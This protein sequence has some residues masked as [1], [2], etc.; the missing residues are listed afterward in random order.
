MHFNAAETMIPVGHLPESEVTA[1]WAKVSSKHLFNAQK[2]IAWACVHECLPT[3][4]FQ[5]RRAVTSSPKCPRSSCRADETV[6]H[7]LWDCSYAKDLWGKAKPLLV[8]VAGIKE[9]TFDLILYGKVDN[10]PQAKFVVLWKILNSL[11]EAL[12]RVRN[13]IIFNSNEV[14]VI[15]CIALSFH[16]MRLY[17]LL[18]EKYSPNSSKLWCQEKW[19]KILK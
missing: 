7:I 5:H 9:L 14:T 17:V 8:Q 3:K 11:K 13:K 1:V 15:E 10:V 18:D 19:N 6:K 12:W 2:D 4:A 16:A